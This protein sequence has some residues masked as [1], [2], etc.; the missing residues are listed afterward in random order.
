M[1]SKGFSAMSK[2]A[3][4]SK[5]SFDIY[6]DDVRLAAMGKDVAVYSQHELRLVDGA[7]LTVKWTKSVEQLIDPGHLDYRI[8]GV[9]NNPLGDRIAVGLA[10]PYRK[11]G[12]ATHVLLLNADGGKL[13]HFP[14][15]PGS[16]DHL[17]FIDDGLLVL[18]AHYTA[19]LGTKTVAENEATSIATAEA[20]LPD[21]APVPAPPTTPFAYLEKPLNERFK[22]WFDKPTNGFGRASSPIG[23]GHMGVMLDGGTEKANIV[24]NVDSQWTGDNHR[25]GAYQGFAEISVMLGHDLAKVSDYRREL[26][27]RTGIHTVTYEYNGTSD[28]GF[29]ALVFAAQRHM[30]IASSRPGSLPANLQGIWNNSNWPAWTS[31]YHADINIQMA[32]WFTEHFKFNQNETYL[33]ERGYPLM[34]EISEHWQDILIERPNGELVSPRTIDIARAQ[35]A[36]I[37]HHPGHPSHPQPV[38]R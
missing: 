30:I 36:T 32:Y 11:S 34:K 13:G 12:E 14:L 35:A 33:H 15:K 23:N 10:T 17:V 6:L 1:P 27:L 38:H 26:D 31:D 29:E 3:W 22:D 7:S 9:S 2:I 19:A 16:I 25:M 37:W 5:V 18:S 24:V 4:E 8:Y 20:N 28:P 21:P